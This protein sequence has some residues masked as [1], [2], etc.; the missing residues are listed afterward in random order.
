MLGQ[1]LLCEGHQSCS[2]TVSLHHKDQR[3]SPS[4]RGNDFVPLSSKS[5][6]VEH[7][8]EAGPLPGI[9][10]LALVCHQTNSA[11]T[12]TEIPSDALFKPAKWKTAW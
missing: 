1:D 4:H 12:R 3:R 10:G 9:S 7:C 2:F 11:G 8:R 6:T 5:V